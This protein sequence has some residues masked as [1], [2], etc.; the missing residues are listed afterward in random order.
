MN[1][2]LVL[3]VD[4]AAHVLAASPEA[5]ALVTELLRQVPDWAEA[6]PT[7]TDV[8]DW[9]QRQ[10]SALGTPTGFPVGSA[11]ERA[12]Q[13]AERFCSFRNS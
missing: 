13:A 11:H 6:A 10:T 4:D 9:A 12:H 2:P 7:S 8:R 1:H 3:L 5:R